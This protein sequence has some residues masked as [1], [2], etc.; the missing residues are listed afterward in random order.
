[1]QM[2]RSAYTLI[3]LIFVIVVIGFLAIVAIPH[4]LHLKKAAD[5]RSTIKTALSAVKCAR[6]IAASRSLLDDNMSFTL[7][8]LVN[9]KARGWTYVA[10]GDGTYIYKKSH[11]AVVRINL[12]R[13][14]HYVNIYINCW[15]FR[16]SA[17]DSYLRNECAKMVGLP[18]PLSYTHRIYQEVFHF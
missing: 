15:E 12:N 5:V 4:F 11:G 13:R 1:M 16:D 3:E 7:K 2:K 6:D 8:D 18:L 9:I 10:R 14:N 17:N